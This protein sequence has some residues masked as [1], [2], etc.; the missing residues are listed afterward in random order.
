MTVFVRR[1]SAF[2]L[3]VMLI[4]ACAFWSCNIMRVYS[5]LSLHKE[6]LH[7]YPDTFDFVFSSTLM[8]A[9]KAIVGLSYWTAFKSQLVINLQEVWF[10]K[11]INVLIKINATWKVLLVYPLLWNCL[12]QNKQ[13]AKIKPV[14]VLIRLF[15][16]KLSLRF[17]IYTWLAVKYK[18]RLC[19]LILAVYFGRFNQR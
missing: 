15:K 7:R 6:I 2:V 12:S 10:N 8:H 14:A 1:K 17:S 13:A 16:V 9:Q 11:F 4:S 3:E 18:C 19:P 5:L